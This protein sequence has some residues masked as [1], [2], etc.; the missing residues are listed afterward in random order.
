MKKCHFFVFKSSNRHN[1]IIWGVFCVL[2]AFH[3]SKLERELQPDDTTPR[4]FD[5]PQR[6]HICTQ[7]RVH[8]PSY[9]QEDGSR[10]FAS[11]FSSLPCSIKPHQPTA[12]A[13]SKRIR[14]ASQQNGNRAKERHQPR[15]RHFP[16]SCPNKAATSGLLF[17]VVDA[18]R[19]RRRILLL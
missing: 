5:T 4:I 7:E 18:R 9:C 1:S 15:Q 13:K 17:R 10:G 11:F 8:E 19:R 3:R 12:R 6:H 14:K 2:A 16:T